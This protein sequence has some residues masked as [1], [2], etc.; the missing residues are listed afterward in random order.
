MQ[1]VGLLAEI[2]NKWRTLVFLCF[3][4][5]RLSDIYFKRLIYFILSVWVFR[6]NVTS[7]YYMPG[8]LRG[9]KGILDSQDWS[10]RWLWAMA[11]VLGTD[12]L[13]EKPVLLGTEHLCILRCTVYFSYITYIIFIDSFTLPYLPA[14][15]K[16]LK[17][18]NLNEKNR[19]VEAAVCQCIIRTKRVLLSTHLCLQ[20]LIGMGHWSGSRPLAAAS[21]STLGPHWDSSATSCCWPVSRRSCSS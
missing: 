8:T 3:L 11:W 5:Y 12:L 7:E 9:Q 21:P 16:K 2:T 20:M 15:Q 1:S 10:Y 6:L 4:F 17:N 14:P 13:E 18:E 19:I